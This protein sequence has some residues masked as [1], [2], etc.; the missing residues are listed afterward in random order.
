[1]S[2]YLGRIGGLSFGP[3]AQQEYDNL[4]E[5][6]MKN[7]GI[8]EDHSHLKGHID[9]AAGFLVNTMRDAATRHIGDINGAPQNAE[10]ALARERLNRLDGNVGDTV[11]S[12]RDKFETF[13]RNATRFKRDLLKT[14][15]DI[16]D[17][18]PGSRQSLDI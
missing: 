4:Y 1:M 11:V 3:K 18:K 14:C 2:E 6:L 17:L 12:L 16:H 8:K 7:A 10:E 5:G 9:Y 13:E 15:I